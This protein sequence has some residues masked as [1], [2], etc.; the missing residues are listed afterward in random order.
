MNDTLSYATKHLDAKTKMTTGGSLHVVSSYLSLTENWL[1]RRLSGLTRYPPVMLARELHN[2]A[3]YPLRQVRA[4]GPYP[5]WQR[6]LNRLTSWPFVYSNAYYQ[7]LRRAA[8]S[9]VHSHFAPVAVRYRALRTLARERFGCPTVCS[10]YGYDLLGL[11]PGRKWP[12]FE[13]L[14]GEE[15][16]F[17]VQGPRMAE[18]LA[19]LGCNP[20]KIYVNPLGIDL[21]LF[22]ERTTRYEGGCFRVLTVGRFVEKKGIEDA[23]RA[24]V[25]AHRK[26][27][28]ITLTIAG[29]G[30]LRSGVE[31]L[32][33]AEGAADFIRLLGT[34]DY[35]TLCQLY[36]SHD[37]CLQ[38]S[39]TAAD[40]DT[41]GGANMCIIEAMASGLP[42]VATHHADTS[43]TVAEGTT[44]FLA[45]EHRPEQ[46]AEA[47]VE[48]AGNV[49]LWGSFSRNGR[50]RAC[51]LFDAH[52]QASELE[53]IYDR[54]LAT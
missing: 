45:D 19:R 8:P 29:D 28:N 11:M 47:L 37:V 1:Y 41:E 13:L 23:V 22:P 42:V 53:S 40:G 54:I 50:R 39:V 14:L 33:A 36:Y 21:R 35:S 20:S 10:F 34:V 46:L 49:N 27:V 44:A 15:T 4:L 38:P 51:Q 12:G 2:A 9:I 24:V 16:A 7:E 31:G 18:H 25:L 52:Q 6:A 17:I 48:L 43:S 26:G 30:E 5:L 32:I 3:A